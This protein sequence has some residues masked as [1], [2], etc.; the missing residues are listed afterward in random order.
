MSSVKNLDETACDFF[1]SIHHG[2]TYAVAPACTARGGANQ[3]QSDPGA[4]EVISRGRGNYGRSRKVAGGLR[5]IA[6][7]NTLDVAFL[8][9]LRELKRKK[10]EGREKKGSSCFTT[11]LKAAFIPSCAK[12]GL[13]LSLA[14]SSPR[15]HFLTRA[16]RPLK[17]IK[18]FNVFLLCKLPSD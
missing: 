13:M 15:F 1:Q 3:K 18:P 10:K 12:D 14:V 2:V 6:S 16:E 7:I 5:R 11:D 8:H 4:S 9:E 17:V